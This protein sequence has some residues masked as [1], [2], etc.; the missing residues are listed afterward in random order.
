MKS[1]IRATLSVYCRD[2]NSG[3]VEI[4]IITD[5]D[6]SVYVEDE[7]SGPPANAYL[8]PSSSSSTASKTDSLMGVACVPLWERRVYE[9]AKLVTVTNRGIV[10]GMTEF[11]ASCEAHRRDRGIEGWKLLQW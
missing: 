3:E 4:L 7:T 6:V 9:K 1:K 11:I 5:D 10:G 2:D 8:A